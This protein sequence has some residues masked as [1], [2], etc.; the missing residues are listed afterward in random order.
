[1]CV[2]GAALIVV[3]LLWLFFWGMILCAEAEVIAIVGGTAF[4]VVGAARLFRQLRAQR[5][6]KCEQDATGNSR[7][8]GQLTGL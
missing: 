6:T 2:S 3:G 7:R 1:M 4:L 8:A 5:R